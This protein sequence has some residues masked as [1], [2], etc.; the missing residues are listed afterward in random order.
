M[1]D[2]DETKEQQQE[3][4]QEQKREQ[5]EKGKVSAE[6]SD[7]K[8]SGGRL[9]WIIM[10]VV[11]IVGAGAGFGVGRIFGGSGTAETAQATEGGPT[12]P[13]GIKANTPDLT[14]D[15]SQPNWFYD[16]EPVVANLDAP[17]VTRYVRLT[18]TL[19]IDPQVEQKKGVV[20]IEEKKPLLTNW[21]TIYLAG[22]SLE[23][24]RGDRN[25]K[26][27][28]SQVLDAFNEKL[29]PDSKPRI[30]RVLFKEFAVQ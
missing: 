11:V 12:L 8:A 13:E 1:A 10:A 20:F 26:S 2:A 30:K 28:Q 5:T 22:L 27:I 3:Q 7:K 4:K 17:G 6:P 19:E 24:I 29:F 25:L 16:L 18:L 23:D 14:G 9:Q 21:L 15:A